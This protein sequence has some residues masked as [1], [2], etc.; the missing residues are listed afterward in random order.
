MTLF[1][2]TSAAEPTAQ[3]AL[4]PLRATWFTPAAATACLG[5]IGAG[6]FALVENQPAVIG[7]VLGASALVCGITA[8]GIRRTRR[9]QLVDQFIK[10]ASPTLGWRG[11]ARGQ[12]VAGRWS[13]HWIGYPKQLIVRY[14]PGVDDSDPQ[15]LNSVR[16]IAARRFRVNYR[17]VQHNTNRCIV[18]LRSHL[19]VD[20]TRNAHI[21]RVE[22]VVG[23]LFG[24]R[25]KITPTA[26]DDGV[27]KFTVD[28]GVNSKLTSTAVQNRIEKIIEASLPGR[29]RFFWDPQ[30][31]QLRAELRPAIPRLVPHAIPPRED[32][33]PRTTYKGLKIPY[34]I[35]EDGN[36]ISWQPTSD[37]HFLAVGPTNSGKTVAMQAILTEA[38]HYG[39]KIAGVDGKRIEFLGFHEWENVELIGASIEDQARVIHWAYDL[40]EERYEQIKNGRARVEDF[41][42][43]LVFIDEYKIFKNV[44]TRWYKTVKPKGGA[45]QPPALDLFSDIASLG[46]KARIHLLVGVQRPDAEFLTGD[47]RDNF[48]ARLSVGRL[49]PDGARMMWNSYFTGV[50]IPAGL[51]GRGTATNDIG[52]PVEVQVYWTPDPH[53]TFPNP[54]SD[55]VTPEDR[56]ILEGLKPSEARYPRLEVKPPDD[57][58]DHEAGKYVE[59]DYNA[60]VTAPLVS[61]T[62]TPRPTRSPGQHIALVDEHDG[63]ADGT[64]DTDPFD[65]YAPVEQA[66]ADQ[67]EQ[68][69]LFLYDEDLDLWGLVETCEPDFQDGYTSITYVDF[70]EGESGALSIPEDDALAV[71]RPDRHAEQR[72]H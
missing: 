46:R 58:F 60:Y 23:Q 70:L 4:P 17:I 69:D 32:R 7:S 45:A 72:P 59:M 35:D 67:L 53:Q 43:V 57:E 50:A 44:L 27:S 12:V 19:L 33:D 24:L 13:E 2:T 25:A 10:A 48:T 29:W 41:E 63:D 66:S 42:P 40:M 9:Q 52:E 15:W 21:A 65:G 47:M 56:S 26:D 30:H 18:K 28:H 68:G 11:L 37:P 54:P 62:G 39:W 49:S 64:E 55:W 3:P 31:D 8:A 34:A 1:R 5:T 20:G 14:A 22:D 71:R 36:T 38:A 16:E 61:Y 51:K 6:G